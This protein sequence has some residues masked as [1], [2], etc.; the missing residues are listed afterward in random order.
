MNAVEYVQ[1]LIAQER[2]EELSYVLSSVEHHNTYNKLASF[3]PYPYQLKMYEAGADHM[4]RFACFSNRSG[5]TYSG[6]RELTYHLTGKY[7]DWFK[8]HKFNKGPIRAWAIGITGDSTRKVLQLELIGAIDVRHTTLIGSGSIPL[9]DIEVG[10]IEKDGASVKVA[11][12]RH[13]NSEG[14]YDGNS[15][16]EFRSTQ[17]GHMALA[18]AAVDFIL[19]DEEDPFDSLAI[20]SQSMTRLATTGGRLLITATPEGKNN[21]PL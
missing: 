4:A 18:G 21:C 8:G 5:K 16:L 9:E 3:K 10:L 11:Y 19:L 20:Y 2:W 7:P 15:I 12:V 13:Y 17:Q 1:E 14:V 6:C